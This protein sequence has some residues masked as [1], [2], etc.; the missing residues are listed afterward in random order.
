MTR[1]VTDRVPVGLEESPAYCSTAEGEL[2]L[3]SEDFIYSN[4][5]LYTDMPILLPPSYELSVCR[6]LSV[7]PVVTMEIVPLSAL[8]PVLGFTICC[9]WAAHTIPESPDV[10]KFPLTFLPSLS[11]LLRSSLLLQLHHRY[12]LS[13]PQLC[14]GMATGLPVSIGVVA[15]GSL[16]SASSL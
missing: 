6:E 14:C 13:A 15:G 10:Y 16:V 7:C 12:C 1:C 9:V 11:C 3:D 4:L 2:V 8:L 5:D